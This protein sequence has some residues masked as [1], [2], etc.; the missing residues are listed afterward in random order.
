MAA[1]TPHPQIAAYDV[2]KHGVLALSEALAAELR[3]RNAQIGVTV[4]MPGRVDTAL[5]LPPGTAAPAAP[6]P[7]SADPAN[8]PMPTADLA[9]RLVRAVKRNQLFV[10]PDARRRV[11][12]E[13]RFARILDPANFG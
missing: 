9:Q 5:G 8:A 6:Q 10:F 13:Q 1:V 4:A 7:G 11:D 3:A 2:S 12:V